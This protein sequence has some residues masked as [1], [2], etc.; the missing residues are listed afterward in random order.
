M[1]DTNNPFEGTGTSA[2]NDSV[3]DR[4]ESLLTDSD[5]TTTNVSTDDIA[6]TT[7]DV[8]TT[9]EYTEEVE[10]PIEDSTETEQSTEAENESQ[11]ETP[12][13]TYIED[14]DAK[15]KHG[16]EVFTLKELID[17]H[18]RQADYTRKTTATRERERE[19]DA[20]THQV[21]NEAL[22]AQQLMSDQYLP[23][24]RASI[25]ASI[26]MAQLSQEQADE[27]RITN[28]ETYY[29]Y[30]ETIKNFEAKRNEIIALE[31]QS[32][33]NYIAQ[34]KALQAQQEQAEKEA[35]VTRQAEARDIFVSEFPDF[36]IPE[37][38]R[39]IGTDMAR[40]LKD[41]GFD[42]EQI[43]SIDSA[44]LLRAAYWAMQGYKAH[45]DTERAKAVLAAKPK[46]S[47]PKI[48][49]KSQ[50]STTNR[51]PEK[52]TFEDSVAKMARLL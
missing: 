28:P 21:R 41:M 43:E 36:A 38:A 35:F 50:S 40:A 5:D 29:Q 42:K 31:N 23:Q 26:G 19:L 12:T 51:T 49:I 13:E 8:E 9:V 15:I 45:K 1:S 11:D 46:I 17:G 32:R 24:L 14:Y 2:Y 44:P 34:Q 27:L 37:K 30:V 4:M 22:V 7:T 47:T 6:D 20:L 3:I 39:A 16:D 10:Q 33:Q 52:R 25:E 48:A 18:L